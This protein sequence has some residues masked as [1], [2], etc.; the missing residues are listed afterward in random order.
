MLPLLDISLLSALGDKAGFLHLMYSG[1]AQVVA[2]INY[3]VMHL[4]VLIK[5]FK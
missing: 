4:D 3:S 2:R 5:G 1:G